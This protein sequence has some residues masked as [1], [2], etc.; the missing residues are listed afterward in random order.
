MT[1]RQQFICD[2]VDYYIEHHNKDYKAFLKMTT[3]KRDELMNKNT[4]TFPDEHGR[5]LCSLP[6]GLWQALDVFQYPRFL[7]KKD[8]KEWFLKKYP[9]FLVGHNY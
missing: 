1:N 2:V 3:K 9:Q 5:Y 7:E 6:E 4:A 8:E